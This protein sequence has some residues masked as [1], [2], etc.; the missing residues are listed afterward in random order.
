MKTS[1]LIL[2]ALASC[3]ALSVCVGCASNRVE[4]LTAA[5]VQP[6]AVEEVSMRG[7]LMFYKKAAYINAAERE[8]AQA[9]NAVGGVLFPV[10]RS[11]INK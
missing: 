1:K 7:N 5:A 10:I 6:V 3:S 2:F 4:P 11:F 8:G 9:G